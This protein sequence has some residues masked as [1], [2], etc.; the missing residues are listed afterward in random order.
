MVSTQSLGK[1]SSIPMTKRAAWSCRLVTPIQL[2][3][4]TAPE[5][6]EGSFQ[7]Q[8]KLQT[9][10]PFWTRLPWD[11]KSANNEEGKQKPRWLP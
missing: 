5:K 3:V 8:R 6:Q 9:A 4:E 2:M 11:S 10:R 1:V 7:P